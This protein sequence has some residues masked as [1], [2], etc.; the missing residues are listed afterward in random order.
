MTCIEM[1]FVARFAIGILAGY[2]AF[3]IITLIFDNLENK[4]KRR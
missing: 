1:S 3:H 4:I 2:G